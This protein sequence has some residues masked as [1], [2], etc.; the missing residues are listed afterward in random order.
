MP[1][2]HEAEVRAARRQRHAERLA[3]AADD[4]RRRFVPHSPGGFSI[5]SEVGLTD[6][7]HEHAAPRAARSVSASTSSSVP[8]K[9]GCWMT[10]AV[11]SSPR[12]SPECRERASGRPVGVVRQRLER[13][14][15]VAGDRPRDVRGRS[16]SDARRHED[17]LRTSSGDCARTAIRQAS[18]SAE[19]AVVQRR[20]RDLHAGQAGHHRLELVDAAAACPGSPRP[21]TACRRCRTRRASRSPRSAAGMW[22]S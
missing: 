16:G 9:F 4:V 12:Y 10:S 7:D 21:G 15:L 22:C 2:G 20:V 14:V 17:A 3:V 8:K 11:T 13:E 1:G 18:A 5:A 19:R 6:R